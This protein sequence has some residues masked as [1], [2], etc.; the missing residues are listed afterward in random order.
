MNIVSNQLAR[1]SGAMVDV[2]TYSLLAM[3]SS[4]FIEPQPQYSKQI[5]YPQLFEELKS[6]TLIPSFMLLFS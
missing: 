6:L 4:E 1:Y 5:Q 2:M 3:A